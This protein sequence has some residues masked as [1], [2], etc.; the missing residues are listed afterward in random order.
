MK[1]FGLNLQI[2]ILNPRKPIFHLCD[3]EIQATFFSLKGGKKPG[4]D[5]INYDIEKQNFNSLLVQSKYMF[6]LYL[7]NDTFPE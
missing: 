6:N 4:L 7:K 5:E 2:E 1:K 3:E